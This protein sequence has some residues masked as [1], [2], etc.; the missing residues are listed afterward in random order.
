MATFATL[1]TD[2][3]KQ[4]GAT[5][6]QWSDTDIKIDM[7]NGL[8]EVASI[9]QM[10][11]GS[12]QFEDPN[13]TTSPIGR[14]DITSGEQSVGI[15][16]TFLKVEKVWIHTSATDRRWTELKFNPD[17]SRFLNKNSTNDVGVPTQFTIIGNEIF[18]DC[19]PNFSTTGDANN[20]DLYGV[21]VLFER[22]VKYVGD[23]TNG[24]L[25][26]TASPG[27]NPQ[28]HK[29]LS[30]YAQRE[31]LE[32]KEEGNN[33]YTKVNNRMIVMRKDIQRF[34]SSRKK[35]SPLNIGAKNDINI[36][37]YK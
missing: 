9:I 29:Y 18:F 14:T 21:R 11:D 31:R 13:N 16:L 34:Y 28:F 1:I 15:D 27:F 32:A 37:E 36:N 8:D 7:N 30:L 20:L 26:T 25:A 6:S 33:H 19:F 3:R 35:A 23:G 5:S 10:A 2:A 24:T 22:N 12:W 4:V 17:K